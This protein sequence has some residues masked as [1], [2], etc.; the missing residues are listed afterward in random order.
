METP[1][2][3]ATGSERDSPCAPV[4]SGSRQRPPA[5]QECDFLSET[6]DLLPGSVYSSAHDD[7]PASRG[8]RDRGHRRAGPPRPA[9]AQAGRPHPGPARGAHGSE[10]LPPVPR[11]ERPPRAAAL[12]GPADRGGPGRAGRGPAHRPGPHPAGRTGDRGRTVR[13]LGALRLPRPAPA[14]HRAPHPHRGPRG[15]R[16]AGGRAAPS[17]GGAGRHPRGGAPRQRP[18]ARP[19][20]R[21]GQ[22]LPRPRGRG[23]SAARRDRPHGRAAGPARGL[24][25]G[26]APRLHPALRPGPAALHALRHGPQARAHPHQRLPLLRP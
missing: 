10:R 5:C 18:A 12:A 16:G 7:P 26:R 22:P 1:A 9:P 25:A 21:G 20:A 4:W 3:P 2:V 24:G 11:G 15:D 23:A 17:P 6:R 14:A 13:A 8:Q 19:D